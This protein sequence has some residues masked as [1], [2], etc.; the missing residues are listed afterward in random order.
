[1]F[2]LADNWIFAMNALSM[3]SRSGNAAIVIVISTAI[4]LD[5]PSSLAQTATPSV[6]WPSADQPAYP[7]SPFHGVTDGN[8]QIIACRCR[9][10]GRQFRVGELVC[11]STHIGVVMARCDL[12]LNNTSWVPTSTPCT[13]S[14]AWGRF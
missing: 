2:V 8:G 13:I 7:T 6:P 14:R 5:V 12:M 1:L 11:M 9:F 4:S 10:K 3:R